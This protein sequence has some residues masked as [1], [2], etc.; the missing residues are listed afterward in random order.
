MSADWW[1]T[2]IGE[3]LPQ[4]FCGHRSRAKRR[5]S[6]AAKDAVKLSA[7][8]TTTSPVSKSVTQAA[9]RGRRIVFSPPAFEWT[10]RNRSFAK[11][12]VNSSVRLSA[13]T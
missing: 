2:T 9:L 11:T 5:V 10:A 13:L 7:L 1:A 12:G 4:P 3:H 6:G 8:R